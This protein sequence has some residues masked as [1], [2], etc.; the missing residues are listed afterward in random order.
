[1]TNL[2]ANQKAAFAQPLATEAY[3]VEMRFKSG[4][5]YVCNFNKNYDWG[6]RT[7]T[8]LGSLGSI[9]AIKATLK[10]EPHPVILGL[11]VA[12]VA[13][14]AL[15]IGDVTEYRGR[16]VRIYACPLDESYLLVDDPVLVWAGSM[17]VMTAS[18]AQRSSGTKDN[19]EGSIS[20]RCE[21]AGS[22]LRRRN[23]YR[24]N[25][26]Q[27]KQL[28]PSDT[29]FDYQVALLADPQVWLSRKFQ[30]PVAAP[31]PADYL[32]L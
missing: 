5:A 17:D 11:A 25:A 29:G 3:F 9:S 20:V 30:E 6:G 18:T 2:T 26:A 32:R 22:R 27:Q 16:A 31:N 21:P 23:A 19:V 24:V 4:T 13:W 1:M 12:Q 7:W 10:V 14:L 15:A 8:G 28:H